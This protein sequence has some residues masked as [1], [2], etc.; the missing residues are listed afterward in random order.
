MFGTALELRTAVIIHGQVLCVQVGAHRAIK[1][2]DAF[3]QCFEE[4]A[5]RSMSVASVRVPLRKIRIAPV[6]GL[7]SKRVEST[8][9]GPDL[10]TSITSTDTGSWN[11]C[12]SPY[13]L[14]GSIAISRFSTTYLASALSALAMSFNE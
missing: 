6:Y 11:P 8:A 14:E 3:P 9:R 1:D 10:S 4:A 13:T 5:H 7:P 2:D 12:K